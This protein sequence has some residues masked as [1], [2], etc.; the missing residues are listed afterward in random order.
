MKCQAFPR[1]VC[2]PNKIT[3]QKGGKTWQFL[4]LSQQ[5][6]LWRV[7]YFLLLA[8]TAF[9]IFTIKVNRQSKITKIWSVEGV[10][11]HDCLRWFL[12]S[13]AGVIMFLSVTNIMTYEIAPIPLLWV[14][15]LCIYLLSFVLI[16]KQKPWL[17]GWVIDK[18][19]L[20]FD[21]LEERLSAMPQSTR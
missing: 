3:T 18:F 2:Y 16:F 21:I 15:P 8:L 1:R 19:Y 20:T 17:P 10:L 12:F 5:L 11:K 6:L 14:A 13:A 9:A 7:M 4:D